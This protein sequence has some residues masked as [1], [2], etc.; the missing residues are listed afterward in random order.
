MITAYIEG[1]HSYTIYFSRLIK[2]CNNKQHY[3]VSG[4]FY[5]LKTLFCFYYYPGSFLQWKFWLQ[6]EQCVWSHYNRA[7][8]ENL[9]LRVPTM[10]PFSYYLSLGY[11]RS[12]ANFLPSYSGRW[13]ETN[14]IC[15]TY[16]TYTLLHWEKKHVQYPDCGWFGAQAVL[17]SGQVY[18]LLVSVQKGHRVGRNTDTHQHESFDRTPSSKSQAAFRA[19]IHWFL[20]TS[21]L[22]PHHHF[23]TAS[24]CPRPARFCLRKV[25]EAG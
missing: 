24:S 13:L 17:G 2:D 22:F 9:I 7:V 12:R 21:S 14:L 15:C 16:P 8:L 11:N 6:P 3:A 19:V 5:L 1:N 10:A 4:K 18:A 20:A 25:H 23:S